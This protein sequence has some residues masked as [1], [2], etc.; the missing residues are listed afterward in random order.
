MYG[1]PSYQHVEEAP[2]ALPLFNVKYKLNYQ[3]QFMGPFEMR[4]RPGEK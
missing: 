3:V 2:T 4:L 1:P